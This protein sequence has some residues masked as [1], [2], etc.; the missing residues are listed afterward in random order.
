MDLSIITVTRNS[1]DRIS[2]QLRSAALACEGLAFEQIIA[3]NGSTDGA[4]ELL[5][6]EFPRVQ[7]IP[8]IANRGFGKANNQAAELAAGEFFLF[9]NPDMRLL[10]AGDLKKLVDWV[11]AHSDAGIASVKLV[12][13]DSSFNREA[14][15]RRFP[16]LW[17]MLAI[18]FKLPHFF[19]H[20]LNRYLM[21][22]FD[23]ER[24]QEVESVRGAFL[25]AR[26]ELV[27]QLGRPFDPR[28]FIWF[29]DVDLC[30]EARQ[31]GWKVVY[32]PIISCVDY[33]GQ[34]FKKM[35]L[36]RKQA[37]FFASMAK[38]FWKWSRF[39]RG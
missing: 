32:I 5:R 1:K 23:T 26:R 21:S 30:R 33:V 10:G 25:L 37:H 2:D 13:P 20:L 18:F 31:R 11:R 14:A 39:A 17:E 7:L 6:K 12:N 34:S 36:W 29:E 28:Y 9:L 4:V 38:Y 16:K 24:E 27:R 22:D 35:P 15:P 19:P 3:D 8:N